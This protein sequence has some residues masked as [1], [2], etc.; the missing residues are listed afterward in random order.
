VWAASLV[1]MRLRRYGF[2]L[3]CALLGATV[4]VLPAVAGSETGPT[5]NAESNAKTCG[6][7]TNC[8]VPPQVE[9]TAPG[10]VT[11]KNASGVPHGVVWSSVPVTPSCNGV[12]VNSFSTSFSGTCSFAQPGTYRFYCAYHGT[13]MSG[14]ITVNPT[15]TTTTTTTTATQPGGTTTTTQP[16]GTTS[17]PVGGSVSASPP[18]TAGSVAVLSLARSQRGRAV[19]GSVQVPSADAGGR[20]EVDL[21]ASPASLARAGAAAPARVGRLVRTSLHA[22][23]LS[24]SVPLKARARGALVRYHHLPLTVKI[25]LTPRQ[26][27]PSSSTRSIVLHP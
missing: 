10:T 26:G 23:K 19:R 18:P 16:A 25:V 6:Y 12:P 11:F 21:L 5:V 24:F 14:A 13:S 4:A 8:W 27:T 3:V 22:G 17:T 1:V 9:L 20:L 15:G 2:L 7:Y